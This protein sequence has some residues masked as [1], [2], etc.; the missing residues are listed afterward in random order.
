MWYNRSRKTTA[1]KVGCRFYSEEKIHSATGKF[2]GGFS[3]LTLLFES[4]L[5]I[6]EAAFLSESCTL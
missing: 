2:W 4:G 3:M 6:R 1:H 5:P